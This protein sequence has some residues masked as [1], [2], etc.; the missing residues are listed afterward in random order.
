MFNYKIFMLSQMLQN[1]IV[2]YKGPEIQIFQMR[3]CKSNPSVRKYLSFTGHLFNPKYKALS[4]YE[5]QFV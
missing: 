3:L 4:Y 2:L 1:S 5:T